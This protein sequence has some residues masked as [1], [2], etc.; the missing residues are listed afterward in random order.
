VSPFAQ[1]ASQVGTQYAS[2]LIAPPIPPPP[3]PE[4]YEY[5][6][7]PPSVYVDSTW[8]NTLHIFASMASF[9]ALAAGMGIVLGLT[10]GTCMGERDKLDNDDELEEDMDEST[11]S[12]SLF[13]DNDPDKLLKEEIIEKI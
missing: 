13:S 8:S 11:D 3:E 2:N 6:P 5:L 10:A 4:T 9:T 1:V 12:P 7:P